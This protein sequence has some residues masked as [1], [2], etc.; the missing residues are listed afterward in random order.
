MAVGFTPS[1]NH[2]CTINHLATSSWDLSPGRGPI[3]WLVSANDINAFLRLI[4]A[5][6][7]LPMDFAAFF[8][9]DS[10]VVLF[11]AFPFFGHRFD[12]EKCEP[13]A[14]LAGASPTFGNQ[15]DVFPPVC[16]GL[17]LS[18]QD[19][20]GHLNHLKCFREEF[21]LSAGLTKLRSQAFHIHNR[22]RLVVLNK[23]RVKIVICT[24][25]RNIERARLTADHLAAKFETEV[26]NIYILAACDAKDSTL[27]E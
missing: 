26:L 22:G 4:H 19:W 17:G 1:G 15:K 18:L 12:M 16:M 25:S 11:S 5:D 2:A 9:N 20:T 24:M 14:A 3:S 23:R 27:T 21:S 8:S 7:A 10:K 13:H 6:T